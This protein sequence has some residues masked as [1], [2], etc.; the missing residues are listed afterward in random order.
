MSEK[1]TLAT[2]AKA[3]HLSVG[4]VSR[5]LN[6]R[7]DISAETKAQVTQV[8]RE[9]GYRKSSGENF[10]PLRIGVVYCREQSDFYR[11]VTA[12]IQTAQVEFGSRRIALDLLQTE[13]LD[14]PSQA[15]LL[16]K[17]HPEDYDGLIINSAGVET[18]GFINRFMEQGT[19]VATFNTD[20]PTSRRLFYVGCSAYI[21]GQMGAYLLGKLAGGHGK[22]MLFGSLSG[23]T[24]WADRLSSA[25]AVLSQEFP[26]IDLVPVISDPK[27]MEAIAESM[28]GYIEANPDLAGIF[29]INNALTCIAVDQLRETGRQD[30]RLVGFDITQ[31]TKD[32]VLD[33]FC[34]ALLFQDPFQ[35][36]YLSVASMAK[37]LTQGDLPPTAEISIT[38]RI[39]MK[40]NI[41][42]Y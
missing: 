24:A 14:Q 21:S 22:V 37:Y 31:E 12:G 8:A 18:A 34:D 38:P 10:T 17:I 36:G 35:Q 11:E 25:Y 26:G 15:E 23:K 42:S 40:Y 2:I 7:S 5:A 41:D 33:G 29:P 32:G 4:T 28:R 16:S 1:V 27:S 39:I 13:Y 20:A 6:D 30:V 19:P 9:L 3:C